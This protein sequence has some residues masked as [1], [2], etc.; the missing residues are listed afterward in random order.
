MILITGGLGF[1]GTHITRALLDL[2]ETCLV[3]QRST[4]AR[5]DAFADEAGRRL[6][7]EQVDVADR[8]AFLEIGHRHKITSIVNLVGVFG[9]SALEPVDDARLAMRTLFNVLEAARDWEVARVGTASTIGVYIGALTE[10]PLREDTPLPMWTGHGIPAFKKIGELLTDHLADATGIEIVNYRIAAAW[11]PLG[12][13]ASPFIAAPELV[14]AAVN[15]GIPD[16]T[17]LR[18]PAYADD[19]L[20]LVYVKDCARAIA[21]LQVADKLS[22]RTYNIAAGRPTKNRELIEALK[23]VVPSAHAE[24]PDGR[25]PDGPGYDIYLDISRIR[26][27]TDYQPAYDT[28]R[29]VADYVDW[30]RTGNPR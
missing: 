7:V 18:S 16:L 23:R 27:D 11:G 29:A 20:D 22:Y 25:D 21:L 4:A 3:V 28:E 30:L 2:G 9:L 6:Y 10:G 8:A 19:G 24:L 14:H 13:R 12:R 15:G 26:Q 17:S 5:P 1:I